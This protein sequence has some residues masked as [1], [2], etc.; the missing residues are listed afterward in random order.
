MNRN[1]KERMI[2]VVKALGQEVIDRAE[3]IVGEG[4][5]MTSNLNIWIR[6]P[7]PLTEVPTL[8]VTREYVSKKAIEVFTRE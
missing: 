3:D 4:E 6:V 1:S 8:E 7:I 5:L 2:E